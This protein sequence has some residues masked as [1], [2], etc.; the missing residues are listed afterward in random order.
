[1]AAASGIK[2][3]PGAGRLSPPGRTRCSGTSPGPIGEVGESEAGVDEVELCSEAL[4]ELRPEDRSHDDEEGPAES[5]PPA[6]PLAV[7]NLPDPGRFRR[8]KAEDPAWFDIAA[9]TSHCRSTGAVRCYRRRSRGSS[10]RLPELESE[11]TGFRLRFR[12]LTRRQEDGREEKAEENEYFVTSQLTSC[13]NSVR[14]APKALDKFL[15]HSFPFSRD[16]V[17]VRARRR[18]Y[19]KWQTEKWDS[20]A[21]NSSLPVL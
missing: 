16:A 15:N 5:L 9:A 17:D 2:P 13:Q 19:G 14:R 12:P 4:L 3:P 11:P 6:V 1:M 18:K 21:V 20:V 8:E 10:A 7:S